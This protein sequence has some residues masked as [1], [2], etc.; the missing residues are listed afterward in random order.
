MKEDLTPEERDSI[1]RMATLM[2][3]MTIYQIN[4]ARNKNIALGFILGLLTATIVR[5]ISNSL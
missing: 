4:K 2:A 5:I 1:K 3:N